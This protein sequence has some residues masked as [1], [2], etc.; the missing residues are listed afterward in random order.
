[1]L[2][3]AEKGNGRRRVELVLVVTVDETMREIEFQR[4]QALARDNGTVIAQDKCERIDVVRNGHIGSGEQ[5][6]GVRTVVGKQMEVGSESAVHTM[7]R[8]HAVETL[9]EI[10]WLEFVD[11]CFIVIDLFDGQIERIG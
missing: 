8:D 4:V 10:E 11:H 2:G 5:Y 9:V 7:D 3:F 1:M 6:R